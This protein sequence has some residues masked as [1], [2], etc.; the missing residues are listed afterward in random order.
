LVS[1]AE[2]EASSAPFVRLAD[3][4]ATAFL[5]VSLAAAG[6]AW[7][8]SGDAVRAVA[9]LVVATPCPLILAAPIAITAGL[10]RAASRGVIIK[11]G[12]ALE[13]LAAGRLLLLDKTGTLTVGG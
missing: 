4:Y 12:V 7:A 13:R 6:F 8:Y 10:S 9:V 5:V 3:R 11:G 1:E 2:A